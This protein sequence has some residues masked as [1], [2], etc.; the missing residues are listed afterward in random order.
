MLLSMDLHKAFDSLSWHYLFCVLETLGFDS[1]FL[2]I[3]QALYNTPITQVSIKGFKSSILSIQRGTRQGCPLSVL[4]FML[5]IEPLA[6]WT[7]SNI[8]GI[9]CGHQEHK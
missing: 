9:P 1:F 3:L 8:S 6:I 5:A 2:T 7:N 4:L